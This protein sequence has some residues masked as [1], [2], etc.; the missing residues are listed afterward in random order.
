MNKKNPRLALVFPSGDLGTDVI[1]GA[2]AFASGL[3]PYPAL[4]VL[5][6]LRTAGSLDEDLFVARALA[7]IP[8]LVYH[9]SCPPP[10]DDPVMRIARKQE[11]VIYVVDGDGRRRR[12]R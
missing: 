7:E 9:A 11:M 10:E 4:A 5:T 2:A 3:M 12:V 6:A 8:A 1:T